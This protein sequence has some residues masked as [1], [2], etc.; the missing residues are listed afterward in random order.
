MGSGWPRGTVHPVA[1]V[2]GVSILPA[3]CSYSCP[4]QSTLN[5]AAIPLF[6]SLSDHVTLL[7]RIRP[8]FLISLR[9]KAKDPPLPDASFPHPP[10]N[11]CSTLCSHLLPLLP[12]PSL[13]FTLVSSAAQRAKHCPLQGRGISSPS[14]LV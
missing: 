13:S 6:K 10:A 1:L 3:M 5:T 11:R 2:P 4:S 7:F 14:N 8:G 12:L 9:G